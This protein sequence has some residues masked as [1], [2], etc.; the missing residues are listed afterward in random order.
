MIVLILKLIAGLLGPRGAGKTTCLNLIVGAA[1]CDSGEIWFDGS[2]ITH[3]PMY[4]HTL[5]T[6]AYI[7]RY[8]VITW[9]RQS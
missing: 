2:N 3:L 1:D 8:H 5:H 9:T 7:F 6:L 4:T